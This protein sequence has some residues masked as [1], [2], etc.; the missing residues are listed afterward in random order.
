VEISTARVVTE[1]GPQVQYVVDLRT[2]Q[3]ADVGEACDE[4]FEIR[5]DGRD[6]RLL[7]HHFGDPHAVRRARMLPRQISAPLDV[8]PCEN[9]LGECVHWPCAGFCCLFLLSIS[10]NERAASRYCSG[11][12]SSI[13][14]SRR[15]FI[16]GLSPDSAC[17]S[18]FR[19][20]SSSAPHFG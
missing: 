20:P 13:A 10:S 3:R 16:S 6:L 5:Y 2:R 11:T 4:A 15:C 18:R 17:A 9:R 1:P 7:Q 19:V 14:L 8:V 12:F